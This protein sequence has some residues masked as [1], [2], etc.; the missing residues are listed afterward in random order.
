MKSTLKVV[1]CISLFTST[2]L[3][4]HAGDQHGGGRCE[5]GCLSSEPMATQTIEYQPVSELHTQQQSS[6]VSKKETEVTLEPGLLIA[7]KAWLSRLFV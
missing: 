3:L 6:P 2:A 7:L 5:T 1:L 4:T